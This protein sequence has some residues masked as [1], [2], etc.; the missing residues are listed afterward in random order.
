MQL[1]RKS[2]LKEVKF[3]LHLHSSY[4]LKQITAWN[5]CLFDCLIYKFDIS[6]TERNILKKECFCDIFNPNILNEE[7][8]IFIKC[9]NEILLLGRVIVN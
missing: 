6:S 1:R 4:V 2:Q 7:Y 8:F 5:S 3:K 9:E